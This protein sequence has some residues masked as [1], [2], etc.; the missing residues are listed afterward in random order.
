[1]RRGPGVIYAKKKDWWKIH[2]FDTVIPL[3]ED[4]RRSIGDEPTL[5][6][7]LCGMKITFA[8]TVYY[9]AEKEFRRK[10]C[11]KC[12]RKWRPL[13]VARVMGMDAE[14]GG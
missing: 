11:K 10:S 4:L 3:S 9:A 6:P 7:A 8:G 12:M 1:M 2:A 5:Y 13:M 14:A